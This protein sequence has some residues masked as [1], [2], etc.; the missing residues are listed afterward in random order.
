ME[1]VKP[2]SEKQ[3]SLPTSTLRTK[4][5][6][7]ALTQNTR[8][9]LIQAAKHLF[10]VCGYDGTSVKEIAKAARVN[11][12]LISY[13]F[14]GKE[15][16][17]CACLEAFGKA[18]LA[19]AQRILT[20]PASLEE[21]RIRLHLFVEEIF[22]AHLDEP[23]VARIV[24]RECELQMP[25]AKEVFQST[26][27]KVYETLV[28]FFDYGKTQGWIRSELDIQAVMSVFLGGVLYS[29]HK[30]WASEHFYG[31][32][33]RDQHYRETLI[34]NSVSLCLDGCIAPASKSLLRSPK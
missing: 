33:L 4:P 8:E 31:R 18:H 21:F 25:I 23:E 6:P 5:H 26:F 2:H 9:K 22:V 12:S 32:T 28:E 3:R 19:R 1:K 15:G 16:L 27:L 30:D 11:I 10:A 34:S 17:Y 13:H 14:Q 20:H 24:M 29:A 7:A